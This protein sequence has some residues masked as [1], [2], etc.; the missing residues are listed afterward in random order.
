MPSIV[1]AV[2]AAAIYGTLLLIMR[3]IPAELRELLP[4]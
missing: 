1:R 3:A 2:V 4:S